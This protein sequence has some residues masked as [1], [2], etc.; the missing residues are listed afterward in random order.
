MTDAAAEPTVVGMHFAHHLA[1][2]LEPPLLDAG[3]G[4]RLSR[5]IA[6]ESRAAAR[7]EVRR[8]DARRPR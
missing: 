3:P 5:V 4:R 1:H 2:R 8:A 7:A 6:V